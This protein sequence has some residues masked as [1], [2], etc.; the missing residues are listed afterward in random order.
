M[1]QL[2]EVDLRSDSAT[3]MELKRGRD[4]P[5]LTQFVE[6]VLALFLRSSNSAQKLS[7][8]AKT[9]STVSFSQFFISV[10]FKDSHLFMKE[11]M[12]AFISSTSFSR[13]STARAFCF[14][15]SSE[16]AANSYSRLY[17]REDSELSRLP[18]WAMRSEG[19]MALEEVACVRSNSSFSSLF[20][21][22]SRMESLLDSI[23]FHLP[24]ASV[25]SSI[26]LGVDFNASRESARKVST[27]LKD[28]MMLLRR[29][30]RSM[31]CMR[32]ICSPIVA[33]N[34][35]KLTLTQSTRSTSGRRSASLRL[36]LSA[37]KFA[38]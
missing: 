32:C 35:R 17:Q 20:R 38:E 25:I 8:F 7:S 37:V 3:S 13:M 18:I 28:L 33:L 10:G 36:F 14:S 31:S 34:S 29:P 16:K 9:L 5:K 11:S 30:T 27:G 15:M 23:S 24:W 2:S 6:R 19:S 1:F 22:S 12:D 21:L 4:I 26:V